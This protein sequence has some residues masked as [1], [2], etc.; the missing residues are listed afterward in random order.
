LGTENINVSAKGDRGYYRLMKRKLYV[1]RKQTKL[2][3]LQDQSEING[4]DLKK[5]ICEA[6]RHYRNNKKVYLKDKIY[7]LA[8][9]SKN[10]NIGELYRGIN[11]FKKGYQ[12]RTDLVNDEN[13]NLL[14]DS[15][16]IL[17]RWKKYFN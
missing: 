10:K 16:T 4:D 6:S 17:N 12:L 2:Q 11:S 15:H 5:V 14:A 13:S 1:Q 9:H 3:W 8:T 7:D